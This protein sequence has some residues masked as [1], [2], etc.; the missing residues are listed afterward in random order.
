MKVTINI[1]Q[2]ILNTILE[3]G[4]NKDQAPKL[5][6]FYINSIIN[7]PYNNFQIDFENWFET[8]EEEIIQEIVRETNNSVTIDTEAG[9]QGQNMG[10]GMS[11]FRG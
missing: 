10:D 6:K 4:Y 5:F 11:G 8:E 9:F 1:P 3:A 2:P 7:H